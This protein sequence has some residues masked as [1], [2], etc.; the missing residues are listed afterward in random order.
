MTDATFK[1]FF[2]SSRA[3]VVQLELIEVSHP[4]FSQTY[5][6]VR[7]QRGG[8]T[9]TL[10]TEGSQAFD[11]RPVSIRRG[12]QTDDLTQA[13][14]VDI[15]DVGTLLPAELDQIV[16]DDTTGTK[17]KLRYWVYRS[18]D[19]T[20]PLIGPLVYQIHSFSFNED[21]GSIEAKARETN[22]NSTGEI[23]T[24]ERFPMLRGFL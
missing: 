3:D 2:L 23:Y 8:V 20:A 11:F 10:G 13:I 19:L 1:A 21:G 4:S 24:L 18:D 7:N 15:G 5:R 14:A 17:P 12:G 16:N 9:V 22:A 6:I